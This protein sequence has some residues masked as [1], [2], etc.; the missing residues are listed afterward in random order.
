MKILNSYRIQFINKENYQPSGNDFD[1]LEDY[2]HLVD[3][4]IHQL[5]NPP[6]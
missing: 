6:Y 2:N 1:P 4:L 5:S 3:S